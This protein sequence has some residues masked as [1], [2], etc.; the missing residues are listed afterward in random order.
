VTITSN[1]VGCP[2]EE[3]QVGM[4]VEVVFREVSAE[5]TLPQFRPARTG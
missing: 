3:V 5:A 4:P 1:V 2:W